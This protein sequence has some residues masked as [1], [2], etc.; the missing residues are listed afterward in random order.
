MTASMQTITVPLGARSYDVVIGE[1]LLARAGALIAPFAPRKRVFVVTDENVARLHLPALRAALQSEGIACQEIVL[2]AGE[3]TKRFAALEDL[4][5]QLIAGEIDRRDLVVAF[6]GGVIGDLAGFAA[7]IVKRGVD[8]V[9]IP[10]TLLA[11]VDSS[12][13]GK[14]AIDTPAGKNLVG[15]FYQPRLVL[16]DIDVL[17]TLPEREMLAGY[18]EIVKYGLIDDPAFFDWCEAYGAAIREGARDTIAQAVAISVK[19]KARIVGADERESGQRALLNLG[20]T[21]AH[22]LETCAGYDGALLHGEA[23]GVGLALA[24]DLSAALGLCARPESARVRHHLERMGYGLDLRTLPGGPYSPDAL[25]AAM[26]HDKKNESGKLTFILA[27]G[28]G[29]AFVSKDV[30]PEAVRALLSA[31]LA[32]A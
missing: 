15:L 14:T 17:A 28:I 19:A 2:P 26:T 23:V 3:H 8:F 25:L 6:G 21:F 29:R 20:H 30:S 16:A 12:V 9:Q 24:F 27:R 7:G 10:T 11:Q 18:A 5:G 31:E 32:A 1:G 13:G 22:A 4:C